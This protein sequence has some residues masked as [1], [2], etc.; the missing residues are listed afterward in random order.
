MAKLNSKKRN[1][2][3][4]S[5]EIKFGRIDS[6]S[7]VLSDLIILLYDLFAIATWGVRM[8]KG[9]TVWLKEPGPRVELLPTFKFTGKTVKYTRFTDNYR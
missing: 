6:R 1:K 5:E 3:F 9:S 2:I 4:V 8:L 7:K